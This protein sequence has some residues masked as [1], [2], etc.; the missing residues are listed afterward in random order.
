M[1]RILLVALVILSCAGA[2]AQTDIPVKGKG[3]YYQIAQGVAWGQAGVGGIQNAYLLFPTKADSNLCV[4][5]RNNNPSNAHAFQMGAYIAATPNIAGYYANNQSPALWT[6]SYI[7]SPVAPGSLS[8]G[9]NSQ[10]TVLVPALAASEVAI[11]ISGTSQQSGSPDT[12]DIYAVSTNAQSC[13]ADGAGFPGVIGVLGGGD[14]IQPATIQFPRNLGE[15]P[16]TASPY[17]FSDA[18][19]SLSGDTTVTVQLE[20]FGGVF[21]NCSFYLDVYSLSGTSPSLSVFIEQRIGTNQGA[22]DVDI[23]SFSNPYTAAGFGV[24]NWTANAPGTSQTPKYVSLPAN[25]VLNGPIIGNI[26][27]TYVL[28]G[29]SPS[30]HSSLYGVCQ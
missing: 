16:I 21:S 4:S 28:T 22:F 19:R 25:T 6:N 2:F 5:V 30:S 26:E 13:Q 8:V 7:V 29:T 15:I 23:G 17:S 18:G 9:Q 3:P 11:V 27:A 24:L 12:A 20:A 1:K 10:T 14:V